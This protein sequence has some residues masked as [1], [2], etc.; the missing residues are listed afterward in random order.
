MHDWDIAKLKIAEY[1]R[2]HR[3][4]PTRLGNVMRAAED[5]VKLGPGEDLEGFMMRHID[6]LPAGIVSENTR[7]TGN[8]LEMYCGLNVFLAALA[9]HQHRLL[10]GV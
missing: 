5:R 1:P 9:S 2:P 7:H 6:E 4:L 3:I 8:G 10:V